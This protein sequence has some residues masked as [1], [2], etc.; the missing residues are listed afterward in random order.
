MK[1]KLL[2]ELAT[3]AL[4]LGVCYGWVAAKSVHEDTLGSTVPT[5]LSAIRGAG[6]ELPN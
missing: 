4:R 1:I 2:N 5:M 6:H 3:A